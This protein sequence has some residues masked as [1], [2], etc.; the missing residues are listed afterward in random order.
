MKEN[1]KSEWNTQTIFI[2]IIMKLRSTKDFYCFQCFPACMCWSF[3]VNIQCKECVKAKNEEQQKNVESW[4]LILRFK[5]VKS[6]FL[7]FSF[8]KYSISWNVSNNV[9]R[10]DT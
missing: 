3:S 8:E 2:M 5:H 1:L 10:I 7:F 4:M 9:L 6:F